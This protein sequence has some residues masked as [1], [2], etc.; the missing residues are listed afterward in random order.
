MYCDIS[1]VLAWAL[2]FLG[3]KPRYIVE[4]VGLGFDIVLWFI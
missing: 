1:E 2:T 3:C 4:V